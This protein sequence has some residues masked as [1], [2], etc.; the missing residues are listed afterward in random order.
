MSRAG[1]RA[2]SPRRA[3]DTPGRAARDSTAR[4]AARRRRATPTTQPDLRQRRHAAGLRRRRSARRFFD[5]RHTARALV[6]G[7][8]RLPR[9][10]GTRS[11]DHLD[12]VWVA[13]E[14][15]ADALRP[16]APIPVHDDAGAGRAAPSRAS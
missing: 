13:S 16:V 1:R 3:I 5:G 6:L 12:E 11:F 10:A 4:C 15:V 8:R 9:A 7:G 2:G 14:F